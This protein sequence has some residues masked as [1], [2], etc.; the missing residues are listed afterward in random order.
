M[1]DHPENGELDFEYC[2]HCRRV[3]IVAARKTP[4]ETMWRCTVCQSVVDMDFE[5]DYDDE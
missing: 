4:T 1:S 5:D 2:C 3:T